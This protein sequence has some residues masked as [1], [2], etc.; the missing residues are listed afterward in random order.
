MDMHA[1]DVV[2][3]MND[4][5]PAPPCLH[6]QQLLL[7]PLRQL[8]ICKENF[9]VSGPVDLAYARSLTQDKPQSAWHAYE[10]YAYLLQ[11][12]GKAIEEGHYQL[13]LSRLSFCC[14]IDKPVYCSPRFQR[15]DDDGLHAGCAM[16]LTCRGLNCCLAQLK[17][18]LKPISERVT[19]A[20]E[21][22]TW[23]EEPHAPPPDIKVQ[24]RINHYKASTTDPDN[25]LLNHHR[26]TAKRRV[27]ATLVDG[28]GEARMADGLS[29]TEKLTADSIPLAWV[30]YPD[31][32]TY[33][34]SGKIAGER[35]LLRKLGYEGRMLQ[36]IPEKDGP[37][38]GKELEKTFQ[39]L[40]AAP[41]KGRRRCRK[42]WEALR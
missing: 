9:A 40:N 25:H 13:A 33:V 24:S 39:R 41:R 15:I 28:R 37:V 38:D 4:M 23:L 11:V 8:E 31:L 1:M 12:T 10:T 35:Y 32:P 42:P 21:A 22:L 16:L 18:D 19:R 34:P 2:D 5:D 27:E 20:F 26:A 36:Q 17:D 29:T 3:E 7:E 30:M 14:L 6:T